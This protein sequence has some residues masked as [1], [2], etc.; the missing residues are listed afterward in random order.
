MNCSTLGFPVLPYLPE[1]AQAHVHWVSDAIKLS[2]LS[3]PPSPPALNLSPHQGLFQWVGFLHQV[4]KVL[5]LQLHH[6]S[7]QWIFRV[8]FLEDWLIWFPCCPGTLKSL[9][10]HHSLKASVLRRSAFFMV[11]LSH[12]YMT[13]GKTVALT[14]RTFDG[15][16]MSLLFNMLSKFVITFH[17]RSK[18]L[19]I[20]WLLSP[21]AVILEHKK[22]KCHYFK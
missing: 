2:Y 22:R 17:P 8:D 12:L 14:K 18:R 20:L 6:Q 9:L 19:L 11:Q 7:F 16:V 21:S 13:T 1:F 4:A 3:S 15:K 5:E 10:W